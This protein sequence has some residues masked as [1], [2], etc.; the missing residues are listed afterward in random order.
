MSKT[1]WILYYHLQVGPLLGY[2]GRYHFSH[3]VFSLD[4]LYLFPLLVCRCLLEKKPDSPLPLVCVSS[5][6]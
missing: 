6:S 3:Q 2:E 5:F 1:D 4:S